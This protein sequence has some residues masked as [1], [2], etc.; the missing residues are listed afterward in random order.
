MRRTPLEELLE[1]LEQHV[2]T[3]QRVATIERELDGIWRLL[4]ML[5]ELNYDAP[6]KSEIDGG[7]S[8]S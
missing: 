5:P 7:A 2:T 8:G 4:K 6:V 3:M 1:A